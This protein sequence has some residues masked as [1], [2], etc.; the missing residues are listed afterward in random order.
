[1]LLLLA[2]ACDPPGPWDTGGGRVDPRERV[3]VSPGTLDFG[4]VSVNG[5]GVG[6]DT[7]TVWNL[8]DV[9][10]VITGH[11]EPVGDGVFSIMAE[12]LLTIAP[13]AQ[14]DLAVTFAPLTAGTYAAEL[15][16][17]PAGEVVRLEGVGSAPVAAAEV[18]APP[19]TVV[20]CSGAGVITLSNRGTEPLTITSIAG[21]SDEFHTGD[22]PARIDPGLSATI[23]LTFSPRL[24]GSRGASLRV[25]SNDPAVPE[26]VI[27]VTALGYEGERVTEA[28]QFTPAA[29]VDIL[30]VVEGGAATDAGTAAVAGYIDAMRALALDYRLAA[31]GSA[32]TC[33]P[34]TPGWAGADEA[35]GRSRGVAE[36]AF[37]AAEGAYARDL[38]SLAAAVLET[39]DD[40]CLAGWRRA[41]ADLHV[42][43]AG[44]GP[45]TTSSEMLAALASTGAQVSA[46]TPRT[47]CGIAATA[48]TGLAATTGG[49]APDVCLGWTSAF[50]AVAAPP[51][52]VGEV[53]LHLRETP[54]AATI[55][56]V[57]DGTTW[58]EWSYD[59]QE[60]AVVFDGVTTPEVGADVTVTY[61]SAVACAPPTD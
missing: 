49:L 11:D 42:V 29:P 17:M 44:V 46:L 25:L 58:T 41:D 60:H 47:S 59:A 57:V 30:L 8:G 19:P 23:D 5:Q 45:T 12:P 18:S 1:M 22:A 32:S 27:P 35:S 52:S 37:T 34:G 33:P 24:G 3:T 20:G 4:T 10:V 28:F 50:D 39:V 9:E 61:V 51:T 48:Y 40:G 36:R 21:T 31:V 54:V 26:L 43:L 56:V 38:A 14:H 13:G 6:R 55:E 15:V 16:V 2:I 53:R 7:F